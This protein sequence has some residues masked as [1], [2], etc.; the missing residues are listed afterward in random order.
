MADV[1]CF[2]FLQE[3]TFGRRRRFRVGRL[4]GWHAGRR[5]GPDRRRQRRGE[6]RQERALLAPVSQDDARHAAAQAQKNRF[7]EAAR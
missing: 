7:V 3:R 5:G 2:Y 4:R 1:V 6:A